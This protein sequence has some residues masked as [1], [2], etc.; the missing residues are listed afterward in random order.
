[1]AKSNKHVY[2]VVRDEHGEDMLC[3]V[4]QVKDRDSVTEKELLNC[5]ER[6]VAERYSGNIIID[7]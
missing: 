5:F 7:A 1:M 6:D 4:N 3:P 2:F